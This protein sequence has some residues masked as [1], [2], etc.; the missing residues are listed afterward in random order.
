MYTVIIETQFQASHFVRMPSGKIEEPH[1]HDWHL[2]VAVKTEQLDENGFAV[3]FLQLKKIIDQ[4][5]KQYD[6]KNLNE[7]EIFNSNIPTTELVCKN[8]HREI[9]KRLPSDVYLDYTLL[10][11]AKGFY[12]KYT[13]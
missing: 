4:T 11:E 12:V 7:L 13:D 5:I 10:Q 8:I 6:N 1:K 9:K 2:S 3:E